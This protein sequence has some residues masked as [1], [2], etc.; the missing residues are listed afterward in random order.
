MK[1]EIDTKIQHEETGE[2]T[3]ERIKS[4]INDAKKRVNPSIKTNL[5]EQNLMKRP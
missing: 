5:A 2:L 3:H 1:R 4:A